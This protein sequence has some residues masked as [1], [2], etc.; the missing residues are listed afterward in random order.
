MSSSSSSS[1]MLFPRS[2]MI[3]LLLAIIMILSASARSV[4]TTSSSWISNTRSTQSSCIQTN[5][6]YG[7]RSSNRSPVEDSNIS[8]YAQKK[9]ILSNREEYYSA[10]DNYA[11]IKPHRGVRRFRSS[12]LKSVTSS[13]SQ[14]YKYVKKV[15]MISSRSP[16]SASIEVRQRRNNIDNNDG[17]SIDSFVAILPPM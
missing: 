8:P 14:T 11:D 2:W 17:I 5:L 13:V 3:S 4:P 16:N 7:R 15:R 1:R 6:A 10:S 12:L 9:R